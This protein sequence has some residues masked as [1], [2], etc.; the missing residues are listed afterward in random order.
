MSTSDRAGDSSETYLSPA[1]QMRAQIA[2]N[3]VWI[4]VLVLL[5]GGWIIWDSAQTSGLGGGDAG[6]VVDTTLGPTVGLAVTTRVQNTDLG[7]QSALRWT[8]NGTGAAI[9]PDSARVSSDSGA[10]AWTL[11]YDGDVTQA[12]GMA[13]E[14]APIDVVAELS[15]AASGVVLARVG[16]TG[17][18]E[19]PAAVE[20]AAVTG[21]TIRCS[22]A[23]VGVDDTQVAVVVE[24]SVYPPEVTGLS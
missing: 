21:L 17:A 20:C 13:G 23:A 16:L 6:S 9:A 12:A 4:A 14:G 15:D 18:G 19:A 10:S 24:G 2:K 1:D 7:T 5:G 8:L 3:R 22:T 11:P